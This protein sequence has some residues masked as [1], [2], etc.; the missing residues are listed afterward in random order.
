MPAE[1]Q[2][3]GRVAATALAFLVFGVG[4]L[5]LG[6]VYFPLLLLL[7]RHQLRRQV[8]ARAVVSRAFALFIALMRRLGLITYEL[9]HLE[10]LQRPGLLILANHPSLIDVVFLISL[11][12]NADCVVRAGLARNLFTFGPV[13]ACSYVLNNE[14]PELL[15]SC[16][17][18]LA[19]GANLIIFPEGTRSRPGQAL[20]MQRGAA[21]IA[22]RAQQAVTP[23]RIRC[24]PPGLTKG[25][26]WW[27]V[28]D[29]ALHFHISVGEDIQI[30]PFLD[31]AQQEP[32]LAAR[33]LTAHLQ[34]YFSHQGPHT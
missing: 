9:E 14:G 27:R 31:S 19:Q 24:T 30:Q 13:R 25:Q 2:K 12:R 29:R 26:A 8:H 3:L 23:I 18:S 21:Q 1:V 16:M 20:K 32:G 34:A 15:Q 5:L 6:S 11:I 7:Q 4:G 10:R 17:D 28:A 22:I 33:R